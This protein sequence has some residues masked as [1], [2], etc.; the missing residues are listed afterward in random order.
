LGGGGAAEGIDPPRGRQDPLLPDDIR[1]Q[2]GLRTL[3]GRRQA[4][5]R[6]HLAALAAAP[7]VALTHP[8]ADIRLQRGAEPA[9]WLLEQTSPRLRSRDQQQTG[10][11]SFQAAACDLSLPAATES[12]YDVR[13][14]IPAAPAGPGLYR[15]PLQSRNSGA[16]WTARRPGAGGVFGRWTGGISRPVPDRVTASL[17]RPLSATSLQEYAECPFRYFL[18][19]VLGVHVT[20]EP[21][22]ERHDPRERG[23]AVHN[24][25][26]RLVRAAIDTGKP[27]GAENAVTLCDLRILVYQA[28]EPRR[29]AG[30][31]PASLRISQMVEAAI[32]CPRPVS[33][34][35]I[36]R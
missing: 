5:R 18:S 11:P 36:R 16:D 10:P 33:S 25:L 9:P 20:E 34:P 31:R 29:G 17:N 4:E 8:V 19:S 32:L 3:P 27:V 2:A 13:L 23:K 15:W 24:V 26:E 14:I 7:V 28:A 6:D 21:D 35:Q 12:E 30:S 22:E 1:V